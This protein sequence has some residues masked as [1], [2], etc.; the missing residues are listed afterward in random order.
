M[1][2]TFHIRFCLW[3]LHRLFIKENFVMKAS[4][5]C[6]RGILCFMH[7]VFMYIFCALVSF[8]SHSLLIHFII[9]STSVQPFGSMRERQWPTC[10]SGSF[11]LCL[12]NANN[13]CLFWFN[14][15][16]VKLARAKLPANAG[17]FTC[18]SQVKKIPRAVYLRY[19]QF[20]CNYR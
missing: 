14:T 11:K 16:T 9:S 4:S 17:N 8:L 6:F 5:N 18:S 2:W 15:Y 1:S 20:T 3:S 10:S 7:V 19:M 13:S 12:S